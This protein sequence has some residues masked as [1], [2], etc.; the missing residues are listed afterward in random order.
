MIEQ[1][2]T[3]EWLSRERVQRIALIS[4]LAGA[5]M[6]GI[7]M[8]TAKGTI[9]LLGRPVG[10]D[11]SAFW[12]AG[13]LANRGR[14]G[15]AWNIAIHTA[16][17]RVNHGAPQLDPTPWF[18]PPVF[19]MVASPLAR[20]PYLLAV[21]LWQALSLA[22]IGATLWK[23]VG[24]RRAVLVALASPLSWSVLGHGQ[25]AYLTAA[26]LGGGLA[27]IG[28]SASGGAL[29]GALVYKPQMGL[30][31]APWLV[32]ERRWAAM[33][34]GAAAALTLIGLSILF[35]GWSSWI[36][37][38]DALEFGRSQ[39]LEEGAVPF[40]KSAS[41]FGAARLWGA[42]VPV[43]YAVQSVGAA[44]SLALI[45]RLRSASWRVRSAGFCA[46]AALWTPYVQDYD[47]AVVGVGAA[48]L[49]SESVETGF[50]PWERSA[51]ALMWAQPGFA[52]AAAQW[53]LLP[54]G[55][56]IT[57]LL[58]W[59]VMRHCPRPAQIT[60]SPFHRLRAASAR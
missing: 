12:N 22:L 56:M 53:L 14:A 18:Y 50:A 9:D 45:W 1:L 19:L 11:F 36:A 58:A 37:F 51:L 3:G 42:S 55:P 8:L 47:L 57:L 52:R 2:R 31:L 25:N 4:A 16:T 39:I 54:T 13:W 48:F 24:D 43:A 27:A 41:L 7:V 21:T 26:L 44:A 15:D 23:I 30:L 49:Y 29:F 10:T 6:L 59:F 20:L 60:A 38:A 34:V 5:A 46:A 33:V 35:W 32:I 40:Y 28:K 17:M